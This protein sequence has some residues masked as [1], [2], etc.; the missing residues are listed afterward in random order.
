MNL[1][2]YL[3]SLVN[4]IPGRWRLLDRLAVFFA[5]Y[6]PF[7]LFFFLLA[8]SIFEGNI[9]IF[10]VPVFVGIL[11]RAFNQ[12]IFLFYQR[13]RPFDALSLKPL[14]DRPNYPAFPSSH[15]AFF[16]ALSLSL[17]PFSYNLA[18]IFIFCTCFIV[19]SRI[20]CRLHW[21]SDI[22]AGFLVGFFS[23]WL[24]ANI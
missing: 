2:L 7:V 4:K 18:W 19:F 12:I 17:L 16:F 10:L 11:A 3:F 14:I 22:L 24:S 6:V 20:Y 15:S 1:D 8:F 23:F 21:P 9:Y 13:K 5:K